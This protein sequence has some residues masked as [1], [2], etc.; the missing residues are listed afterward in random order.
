MLS[1]AAASSDYIYI[2][3]TVCFFGFSQFPFIILKAAEVVLRNF[4]HA[5]FIF[6]GILYKMKLRESNETH[7]ISTIAPFALSTLQY[8][9]VY[10]YANEKE[11]ER[12]VGEKN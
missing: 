10:Y 6:K 8:F 9:Y 12:C 7:C 2:Y 11:R 5:V 3:Y 1:S 4:A